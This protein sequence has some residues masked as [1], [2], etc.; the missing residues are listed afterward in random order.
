[1]RYQRSHYNYFVHRDD[2]VVIYNARLG[3]FTLV[4][5]DIAKNIESD[6]PLLPYLPYE[7][8]L[9]SGILHLGNEYHKVVRNYLS[10]EH[11]YDVLSIAI[12]P[13]LS[14]NT[15][16]DYCYQSKYK[17]ERKMSE[18][19]Q[20]L[21][22]NYIKSKLS[23]GWKSLSC[24]WYGGEPLLEM[25][26]ITFLTK[27]IKE[28]AKKY[29]CEILPMN[30]VTNG[31]LLDTHTA[32]ILIQE[33]IRNVQVSFDSLYHDIN[34]RGVLNRDGTMS[35]ILVNIINMLASNKVK[36]SVRVNVSVS[37]KNQIGDIVHILKSKG[38]G[39]F[40]TLERIT[41][42]EYEA[43]A[44]IDSE[45]LRTNMR[46]NI[47]KFG[48]IIPT[49][50]ESYPTLSRK[51]FSTLK[52]DNTTISPTILNKIMRDLT[53]KSKFCGATLGNLFVI[54][55]D[56]YVSRCWHSAGAKS[57]A[58]GH[59]K[60]QQ[61]EYQKENQ[62]KW[63]TITPFLYTHCSSCKVLPLCNGGCSHPRVTMESTFP[64]CESIKFQINNYVDI[65]GSKLVFE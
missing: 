18:E 2:G 37:N 38:L 20:R 53:P 11:N 22:L 12:A 52:S 4:N 29:D 21:L 3:S 62:N 5:A 14:C 23:E 30:L 6:E 49:K 47:S 58:I 8:L 17:N 43:G 65:I 16:C 32:E 9:A 41:D 60:Y 55:S 34:K 1:M 51:Q 27:E 61:M 46:N 44:N 31:I 57:E 54:D 19:T 28:L 24:T 42:L 7:T 50:N 40:I 56:G 15:E 13:T 45:G 48:K 39:D 26:I 59:V 63:N 10:K 33:G 25:N 35:V 64:P 36:L